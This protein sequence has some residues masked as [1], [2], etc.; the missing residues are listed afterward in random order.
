MWIA[1]GLVAGVEG[2]ESYGSEIASKDKDSIW[3]LNKFLFPNHLFHLPQ[4]APNVQLLEF[5]VR[6]VL[7]V[8]PIVDRPQSGWVGGEEPHEAAECISKCVTALGSDKS[9]EAA[10][11]LD[12]LAQMQTSYSI[13]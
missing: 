6:A 4:K 9:D 1:A 5:I 11:A 8:R 13:K 12:R 10:V 7:A 3:P 2:F